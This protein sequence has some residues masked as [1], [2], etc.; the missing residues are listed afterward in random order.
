MRKTTMDTTELASVMGVTPREVER[1][2]KSLRYRRGYNQREDVVAKRKVY[3]AKRAAEMRVMRKVVR[4]HPELV[5]EV[6]G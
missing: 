4:E 3:N 2:V 5:K 1:L 6:L